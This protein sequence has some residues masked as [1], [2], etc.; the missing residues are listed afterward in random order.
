MGPNCR[1]TATF[2]YLFVIPVGFIEHLLHTEVGAGTQNLSGLR[3]HPNAPLGNLAA[4][5]VA[6]VS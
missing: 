5:T 3:L 1:V 2:A 4:H 6:F